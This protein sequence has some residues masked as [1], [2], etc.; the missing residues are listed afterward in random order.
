MLGA[1]VCWWSAGAVTILGT[2][3]IIM[4]LLDRL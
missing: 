1:L 3:Y 2:I 4:T